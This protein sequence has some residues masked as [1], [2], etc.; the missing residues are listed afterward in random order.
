[1]KNLTL[2]M[3]GHEGEGVKNVMSCGLYSVYYMLALKFETQ[4]LALVSIHDALH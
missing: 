3:G 2:V 4:L 1:M